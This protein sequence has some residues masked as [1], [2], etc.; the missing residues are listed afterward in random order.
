[1]LR[2]VDPTTKKLQYPFPNIEKLDV[3]S[4]IFKLTFKSTPGED[5]AYKIRTYRAYIATTSCHN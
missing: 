3:N 1:M 2:I 4:K 5:S